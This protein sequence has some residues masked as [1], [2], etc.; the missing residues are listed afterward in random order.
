MMMS[1]KYTDE[2]YRLSNSTYV[3]SPW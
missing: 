3:R 1:I 2:F